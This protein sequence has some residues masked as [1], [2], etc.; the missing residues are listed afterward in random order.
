MVKE[1]LLYRD[2]ACNVSGRSIADVQSDIK[3]I[4]EVDDASA[5]VY[6]SLAAARLVSVQITGAVGTP[7][8]IAVPA[9]T[10]VSRILPLV[11]GYLASGLA[12]VILLCFKTATAKLLIFTSR[13]WGLMLPMILWWQTMRVC[14]SGIKAARWRLQDLLGA[15]GYLKWPLVK[16]RFP[17]KSCFGFANIRLMAPGTKAGP[18]A[19]QRSR[20]SGISEP[21]KFGEEQ[22]IQA[23]QALQIRFVQTRSQTD[24]KVFG[25]VEKPFFSE[26]C[27]SYADRRAAAERRS[28]KV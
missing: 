11:G 25:A 22:M 15:P 17:S 23:G 20:G 21:I 10:P 24:V 2:A 19:V 6:V 16:P 3:Q 27:K 9:Y 5:S 12:R 18:A 14:M 4:L 1:K 13:F 8:T 26:C 7:G 28:F